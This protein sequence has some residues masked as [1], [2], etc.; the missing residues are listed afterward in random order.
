[1]R[2]SETRV[3]TLEAK[4]QE[5]TLRFGR[6]IEHARREASAAE[7]KAAAAEAHARAAEAQ[8]MGAEAKLAEVHDTILEG[9]SRHAA[10]TKL[11]EP[12]RSLP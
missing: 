11:E 8:M 10:L 2:A 4:M 6:E 12:Q 9:L 7:R 3:A 1:M 5:M